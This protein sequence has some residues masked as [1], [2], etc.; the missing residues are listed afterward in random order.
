MQ[1]ALEPVVV[2]ASWQERTSMD[3]TFSETE[4]SMTLHELVVKYSAPD[5][6]KYGLQPGTVVRMM[7]GRELLV[8]DINT[9]GGV[10]DDCV[11]DRNTEV[12]EE[13]TF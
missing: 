11:P 5:K 2:L 4:G 8:G 7:D 6:G 10:C 12:D 1:E 3:E 13:A 9:V